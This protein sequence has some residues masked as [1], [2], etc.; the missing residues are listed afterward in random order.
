MDSSFF[1]ITEKDKGILIELAYAGNQN[2]MGKKMDECE[3]CFLRK[4][5]ALALK[6]SGV[7][8]F[9]KG[10]YIVVLDAY[11]P[12]SVQKEM[13]DLVKNPNYVAP[14][15][16]G[17]KHNAGIAVDVT[18]ADASKVQLDMGTPFDD[19][20]EKAHFDF[21]FNNVRIGENRLLLREIMEYSG[22]EPYKNEWWH[23]TFRE[24]SYP[25][26]DEKWKCLSPK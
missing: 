20:S 19:F 9:K 2:F 4:E 3:R 8:A 18:L 16:L 11:R 22:F 13:Y 7:L 17:S 26:S 15:E 5:T 21:P 23:F 12:L 14:P 24:V 25:F 10:Y 1:E 6:K